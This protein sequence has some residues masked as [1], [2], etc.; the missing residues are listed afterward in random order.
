[1]KVGEYFNSCECDQEK[2]KVRL[3][4]VSMKKCNLL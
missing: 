4:S 2:K 1:M 3:L